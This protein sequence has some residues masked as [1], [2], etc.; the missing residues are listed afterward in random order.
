MRFVRPIFQRSHGCFRN[1]CMRC[2]SL[3]VRHK[4]MYR[5]PL[6]ALMLVAAPFLASLATA[7]PAATNETVVL[8]DARAIDGTGGPPLEH[9]AIVIEGSRIVAI[10]TAD[11]LH[12]PASARLIN[13]SGRTVV[14]GL[15]SDHSQIWSGSNRLELVRMRLRRRPQRCYYRA[16][17]CGTRWP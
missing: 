11:K 10:G 4:K 7:Q 17:V 6:A 15:I 12:W 14:P 13:Y 3:K 16:G 2:T 5:N 8:Q 1:G 9:A